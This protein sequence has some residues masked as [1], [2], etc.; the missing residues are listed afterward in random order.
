MSAANTT[1]FTTDP[2][3]QYAPF[4]NVSAIRSLFVPGTKVMISIGG[5]GDTAGLST[6]AKD[7]TSRALYAK[8]I[9]S[10]INS[11]GV[12]GVGMLLPYILA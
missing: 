12:D 9:A 8:N 7:D 3:G 10:L 1:L 6:G 2:P 5:W 4:M 11:T